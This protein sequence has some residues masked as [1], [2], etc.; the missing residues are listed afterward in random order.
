MTEM[1]PLTASFYKAVISIMTLQNEP[2]SGNVMYEAIL[3]D[4]EILTG[5]FLFH[6]TL[7]RSEGDSA[8]VLILILSSF[9]N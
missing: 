7:R 4:E 1:L 3:K 5:L 8:V 9:S 2:A 6:M